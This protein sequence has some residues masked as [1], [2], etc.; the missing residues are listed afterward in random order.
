MC[1]TRNQH[2][3]D[4]VRRSLL[5]TLCARLPVGGLCL[6]TGLGV[7]GAAGASAASSADA[8]SVQQSAGQP[9]DARLDLRSGELKEP[10]QF[11][12]A[13]GPRPISNGKPVEGEHTRLNPAQGGPGNGRR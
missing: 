1:N 6:L 7:L 3:T 9:G 10:G 4:P 8:A 2:K 5:K 11:K 12:A 13:T